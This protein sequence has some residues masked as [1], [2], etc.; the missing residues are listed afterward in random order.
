MNRLLLLSG[1]G[2]QSDHALV[3]TRNQEDSS[4]RVVKHPRSRVEILVSHLLAV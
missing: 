1:Q 2:G 3:A 4:S